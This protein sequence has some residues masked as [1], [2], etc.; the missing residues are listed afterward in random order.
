MIGYT[1]E[2]KKIH[3]FSDGNLDIEL[4]SRLFDLDEIVIEAQ[5]SSNILG[6]VTGIEHFTINEIG[7]IPSLLGE[8]DVLNVLKLLPGVNSVGEGSTGFNVRGGRADQNLVLMDGAPIYN[9][10]HVLG[11]FSIFNP[12]VV[13]QF[14]LFKGHIPASYGGRLSSVLNVSVK[15]E[16]IEKFKLRGGI[17]VAASR[18]SAEVPLNNN[19]SS[20]L[21]AGRGSYSDWL[22]YTVKHPEIKTS[23]AAFYDGNFNH[24]INDTNW[25]NLSIYGSYDRFRYSDRFGYSWSNLA[26]KYTLHQASKSCQFLGRLFQKFFS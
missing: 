17:G 8:T 5:E 9:A 15:K 20:L 21:L 25:L 7:E 11:L 13:D 16:D 2:E 3:L 24:R 1:T 23:R 12:D 10:S 22:L 4:A 18:I 19:K 6:S 26:G 14:S